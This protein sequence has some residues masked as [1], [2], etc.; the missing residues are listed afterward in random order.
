[1]V[2]FSRSIAAVYREFGV[3]ATFRPA[4]G[5]PPKDGL[6]ILDQPGGEI[7]GGAL[8][9]TD[10]TLRF[11]VATFQDVQKGDRFTLNRTDYV[12]RESAQPLQDGLEATVPLAKTTP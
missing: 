6:V 1:M 12:A 3:Q 9:T 11:P 4:A 5:G 10:Y 7:F 2:D 8:I